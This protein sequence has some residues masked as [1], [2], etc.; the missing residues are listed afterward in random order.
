MVGRTVR[1]ILHCL[2]CLL[3]GCLLGVMLRGYAGAS[4]PVHGDRVLLTV[5]LDDAGEMRTRCNWT[6]I[7]QLRG[8]PESMPAG[9]TE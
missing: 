3:V 7:L 1:K 6:E 5:V 2:V 9:P 4:R 8:R